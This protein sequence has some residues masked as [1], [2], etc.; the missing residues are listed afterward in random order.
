M[1]DGSTTFEMESFSEIAVGYGVENVKVPVN[2]EL[3]YE[4]DEFEVTFR[5]EGEVNVPVGDTEPEGETGEEEGADMPGDSVEGESAEGSTGDDAVADE[6]EVPEGSESGEA[7]GNGDT[8]GDAITSE[9]GVSVTIENSD[10]DKNLEFRVDPL[11]E[12]AEEYAKAAA[13]VYA[14]G[15]D[16]VNALD[17]QLFLQVLSYK[18]TYEPVK[19][20]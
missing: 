2:E 11:D 6:A 13:A 3:K 4:T 15:T 19:T 12:E 10:L 1:E 9:G 7:E 17:D 8:E 5:I 14:E 20:T 18:V 16:G